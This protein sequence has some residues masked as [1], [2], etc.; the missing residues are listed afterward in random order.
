MEEGKE[1][2][3]IIRNL[4][5][6]LISQIGSGELF[7]W[8]VENAR[9]VSDANFVI[10]STYDS[11]KE[12]LKIKAV[13]GAEPSLINRTSDVLGVDDLFEVEY[14]V[15]DSSKFEKFSERK[16]REPIV[17]DGFH[18]YSFGLFDERTCERFEEITGSEEIVA[19]PLLDS[20]EELVG[21]LGYLFPNEVEDR[22]FTPLMI[23]G[24][25]ACRA[26]GK[27][28]TFDKMEEEKK[29][30]KERGHRLRESIERYRN[31]IEAS[32]D[33]ILLLDT[34]SGEIIEAN[35][36]AENLFGMSRKDII[37]SDISEIRPDRE[38]GEYKRLFGGGETGA[39]DSGRGEIHIINNNGEE[40][41][42][43][44]GTSSLEFEGRE[45]VYGV[46]R[47]IT[48]RK[49]A[50]ERESFLH[51]LLRH[52]I[53][54]SA[55]IV[56]GHLDL[57]DD[58]DLPE[59]GEKYIERAKKGIIEEIELIEK[60]RTLREADEERI[61][62]VDLTSLIQDQV[63]TWK[64]QAEQAGMEV[65]VQSIQEL[66][67]VKG[68]SLLS[69]VFTNIFE[70][71]IQHSEGTM[72]RLKG[73]ETDG[74]IICSIEDDGKGISEEDREKIFDK[75]YSTDKKRGTGLGMFLVKKLLEIYGGNIEVK[76]SDLGGARFD[77]M[78]KKA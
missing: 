60:V 53:R 67:E 33:T 36:E 41:P 73:R 61:R 11:G 38:A 50:E 62:E 59:E 45:V 69:E 23:F 37:G 32:P 8:I 27:S 51:T 44:V 75:G 42:V 6:N 74:E 54:N 29:E 43:E 31:L 13:S 2:E 70:N 47:D 19:V 4:A 18:E 63:G 40:V 65:K 30:L 5:S 55:Q 17:L 72:I 56:N 76:D 25:L 39:V 68:G 16:E 48:E 26:I 15:G 24:D 52:D 66:P 58:F 7:Q 1:M 22:N 78:L 12:N 20:D 10:L 28:E 14:P 49:K 46:F 64:A 35:E 34:V 77:V 21:I 57:L 3:E 9:E 71:S